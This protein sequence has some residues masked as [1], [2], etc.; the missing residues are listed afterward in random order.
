MP[1]HCTSGQC[2]QGRKPCPT[3]QACENPN[4]FPRHEPW[5][6]VAIKAVAFV[7]MMGGIGLIL[8]EVVR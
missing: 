4:V 3:P 2:K 7:A 1:T 8:S 6:I 5:A